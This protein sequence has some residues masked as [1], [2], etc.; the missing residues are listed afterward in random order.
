MSIFNR[1]AILL[2]GASFGASFGAS[3]LLA[4]PA[5]A[6]VRDLDGAQSDV[7]VFQGEVDGQAAVFQ[8]TVPADTALQID[9][10]SRDGFDPVLRVRDASGDLI[11]ED[12][13][14]GGELNSRAR[15]AA[16]DSSRRITIEVDSFSAEWAE[17]D[18]SYG[19]SFDLRISTSD[20][21][22]VGTR[23]VSYGASETGTLTGEAHLFTMQGVAGQ[24]VEIALVAT[25]DGLDPYLE[26]RDA[27]GETVATDDDGGDGLNSLLRHTF[28]D[29]GTYTIAASGLGE[30]VGEYR[31]RVRERREA[32][33][34]LPLQVIGF[35]DEASGELASGYGETGEASLVPSHIDYQLS[36]AAKSAIRAGNGEISIRMS[37]SGA[38]DPDF[39]GA[40]DSYLEL[41]FDTPM[42]FAVVDSDDDGGGDLDALL[43][44]D[45]GLIAD[46]PGLLDM[47][48]IR[49]QGYGGTA[50]AYTLVI[51][52]GM[53]ARAGSEWEVEPSIQ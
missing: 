16:Q 17:G 1:T 42:G 3:A 24:A 48:R 27:S 51:T 9:A 20:H 6:Q 33:A 53:E 22:D 25:E 14:G 21:V 39:G 8:L 13:D 4:P 38:G 18:G 2:A 7:R 5:I 45:L 35:A 10:I 46:Q 47:L 49:A 11:V 31:F 26:L 36:D 41:G 44:V 50:G 34:Q 52:Q 43:P 29:S 23:A 32:T 19:G 40:I 28:A 15:I 30:S 37:G 12:D